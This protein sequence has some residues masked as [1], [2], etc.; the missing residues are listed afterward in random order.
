MSLFILA[1]A[2]WYIQCI[3]SFCNKLKNSLEMVMSGDH[4]EVL[5]RVRTPVGS[6]CCTGP[7][8]QRRCQSEVLGCV[9]KPLP[10][11]THE[12][13]LK[14]QQMHILLNL[15]KGVLFLCFLP[16]ALL[17]FLGFMLFSVTVK[18]RKWL[19]KKMKVEILVYSQVSQDQGHTKPISYEDMFVRVGNGK[20]F[21]S[22]CLCKWKP[23]FSFVWKLYGVI[24]KQSAWKIWPRKSSL[25]FQRWAKGP[26]KM[27]S[28]K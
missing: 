4:G 15:N 5:P 11:P 28:I 9:P 17:G 2:V 27:C 22:K 20:V 16:F 19:L 18:V 10:T 26:V 3:F 8:F 23:R 25:Q 7:Y 21:M 24:R 13:P 12:I 14:I 1:K 6:G